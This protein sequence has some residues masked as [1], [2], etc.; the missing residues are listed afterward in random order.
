MQFIAVQ[1]K[2]LIDGKGLDAQGAFDATRVIFQRVIDKWSWKISSNADKRCLCK[3][4]LNFFSS[5]STLKK[6][7]VTSCALCPID[8]KILYAPAVES[9]ASSDGGSHLS[10]KSRVA[11]V[12]VQRHE[13]ELSGG[14]DC[15]SGGG[16]RQGAL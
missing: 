5:N 16:Q 4:C 9:S 6:H 8:I 13:Q 15:S 1:Q 14:G 2:E 11:L 7:L 3:Y 10:K 12:G